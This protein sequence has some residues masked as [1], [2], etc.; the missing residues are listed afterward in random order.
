ML[1]SHALALVGVPMRRVIRI[2][3]EQR[4]ARYNLLKG[5]FHGSDD[6][7][8]EDIDHE[9]LATVSLPLT[10]PWLG[11]PV[12]DLNFHAMGVRLVGLRRANGKS[13][14]V[15]DTLEFELNDT[16]VISGTALTLAVAE[17]K[18]IKG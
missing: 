18:L 6:D 12:A 4:D 16:L 15:S 9:R 8:V 3:Q 13:E 5:Y 11:K 2:V 14:P 7:T 10:S 1:A 17:D